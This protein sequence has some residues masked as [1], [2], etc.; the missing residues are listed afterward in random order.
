MAARLE[1]KHAVITG[2]GSGMGRAM[3]ELFAAEGARVLCADISGQ[4]DD[5]ARSLGNG[6]VPFQVDVSVSADVQRMIAAAEEAFGR[7]DILVNNAGIAQM[8]VPMHEHPEELFDQIIA[9]N[10]K[11]VFLGMKYGIAS[12][13]KTGGGAVVNTASAAGLTAWKGTTSYSAAKAGVIQ[14]SKVAAVDYAEHNIRVNAIC[15]GYVWTSILPG[16]GDTRVPPEGTPNPPGAPMERWA[17]AEEIA[18]AALFLASDEASFVTGTA[19][20]VDG[21]YVAV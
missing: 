6:G 1:G 4:Q 19:F 15:P 8:P 7:I 9:V 3:A 18:A 17:L 12:M 16:M 5:V 2:A 21:G 14:L 20:P 13:L 10:L 11:S